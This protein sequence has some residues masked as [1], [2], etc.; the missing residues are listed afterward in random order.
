MLMG[1]KA[2]AAR[3]NVSD[4]AFSELVSL[5][6]ISVDRDLSSNGSGSESRVQSQIR[7]EASKLGMKLWRNNVG[8][9]IDDRRIPVRYGLANE[10]KKMNSVMKSS[11]L[12]GIRPVTITPYHVGTVI[13]QFVAFEVKKESW[14]FSGNPRENAQFNFIKAVV[15]AGGH[16]KFVN[17][18]SLLG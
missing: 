11:D 5:F 10:S 7:L 17:N 2:W 14:V 3:N 1:L 18:A 12:I 16:A 9:F 6:G 13:G 15:S 4:A 8:V